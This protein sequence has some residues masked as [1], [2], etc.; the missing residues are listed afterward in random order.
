MV[1]KRS[2]RPTLDSVVVERFDS[3]RQRSVY[4]T[5]RFGQRQLFHF[6]AGICGFRNDHDIVRIRR[7]R[8]ETK[9]NADETNYSDGRQLE[10]FGGAP[11]PPH[12]L[13]SCRRRR[14]RQ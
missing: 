3:E 5:K 7:H 8:H 13:P 10:T 14:D 6:I 1:L 2:F 11:A 4:A 12:P 9:R